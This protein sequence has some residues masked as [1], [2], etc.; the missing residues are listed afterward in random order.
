MVVLYGCL[1]FIFIYLTYLTQRSRRKSHEIKQLKVA[2]KE[3][4]FEIAMLKEKLKTESHGRQT[5]RRSEAEAETSSDTRSGAFNTDRRE[6]EQST[7]RHT[8]WKTVGQSF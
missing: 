7:T 8:W 2:A 3:Y 1:L 6:S 4:L 5:E